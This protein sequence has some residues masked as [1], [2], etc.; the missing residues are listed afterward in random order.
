MATSTVTTAA[1]V[2]NAGNGVLSLR[3]AVN[4]ANATTTED[5]VVDAPLEVSLAGMFLMWALGSAV[6]V[7][8][9]ALSDWIAE[10]RAA[11][12]GVAQSPPGT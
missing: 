1:D 12:R 4:L 2:V 9:L 7:T 10:V 11:R 5:L 3:E 6:V 8:I